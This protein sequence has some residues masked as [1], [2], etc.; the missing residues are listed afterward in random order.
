MRMK[1][2]I[3]DLRHNR[4]CGAKNGQTRDKWRRAGL[5][6]CKE[7]WAAV[8]RGSHSQP[9]QENCHMVKI[10]NNVQ[11]LHKLQRDDLQVL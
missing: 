3:L 4:A 5:R 9:P 10:V 8:E 1:Y 7:A 6:L 11:K 2:L